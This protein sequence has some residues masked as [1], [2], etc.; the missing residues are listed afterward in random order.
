MSSGISQL[1]TLIVDDDAIVCRHTK[2]ILDEAGF[3]S[4][5]AES[6]ISAVDMIEESSTYNTMVS[7][8]QLAIFGGLLLFNYWD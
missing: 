1:Y 4:E 5:F 3:K 7:G 2:M 8:V 6:G